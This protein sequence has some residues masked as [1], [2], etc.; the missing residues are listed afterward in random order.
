MKS[1][2]LSVQEKKRKIDF[3]DGGHGGHLGFPIGTILAIF[4]LQ[5]TPMLPSK[6]EVNWPFGSGEE[7]KIQDG[8]HGGH[9]GFPIGM[10]LAI[11]DLQVTPMLPSKFEVNWPFG[12]GEEAKNRFSRW[13]PWRPSWI[14]DRHNFSY[15]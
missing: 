12:S 11:F 8:G 9:L 5:V 4:D 10:I 3:Q 2:G 7:A 6:F 13:P 15:F 14:S 1:I